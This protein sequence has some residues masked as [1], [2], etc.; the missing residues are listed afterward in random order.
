MS[1]NKN[2]F[3]FNFNSLTHKELIGW[4]YFWSGLLVG[5]IRIVFDFTI[6]FN[7]NNEETLS[8]LRFIFLLFSITSI[9]IGIY[10]N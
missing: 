10:M 9:L 2:L 1:L 3:I 4:L 8:T 6:S 7:I 5:S